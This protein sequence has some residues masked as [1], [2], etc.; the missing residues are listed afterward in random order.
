MDK[1]E[2]K[3]PVNREFSCDKN[4]AWYFMI[5]QDTEKGQCVVFRVLLSLEQITKG[6]NNFPRK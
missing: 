5:D 6:I 4:C 2:K 3:C 1:A